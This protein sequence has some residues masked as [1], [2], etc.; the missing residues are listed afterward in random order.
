MLQYDAMTKHQTKNEITDRR[1][2][3]P[4]IITV[5]VYVPASSPLPSA[6]S[7][8]HAVP[9]MGF[10]RKIGKT[11]RSSYCGLWYPGLLEDGTFFRKAEE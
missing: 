5:P 1:S 8:V 10:R 6:S 3:L 4:I 9:V 7:T 11:A 2:D